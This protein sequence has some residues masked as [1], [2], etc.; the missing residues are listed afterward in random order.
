MLERLSRTIYQVHVGSCRLKPKG[1][2]GSNHNKILRIIAE[3]QGAEVWRCLKGWIV[4]NRASPVGKYQPCGFL[5]MMMMMMMNTIGDDR[6]WQSMMIDNCMLLGFGLNVVICYQA[7]TEH[8]PQIFPM[9]IIHDWNV[10]PVCFLV[11][12]LLAHVPCHMAFTQELCS[13][14]GGFLADSA[15]VT[16]CHHCHQTWAGQLISPFSSCFKLCQSLSSLWFF[17]VFPSQV[18]IVFI[19]FH[20]VFNRLFRLLFPTSGPSGSS[21]SGHRDQAVSAARSFCSAWTPAWKLT[22]DSSA[23]GRLGCR[24]IPMER[25]VKKP[26]LF[27]VLG[28]LLK[29]W[30]KIYEHIFFFKN[31]IRIY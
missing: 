26:K 15:I 28:N 1:S 14:F 12:F 13:N 5:M 24:G 25:D 9:V 27:E 31:R 18:F 8:V 29:N 10:H 3:K 2:E 16:A 6:W 22:R 23:S 20:L 4:L 30:E 21:E 11:A 7:V 17:N 19:D